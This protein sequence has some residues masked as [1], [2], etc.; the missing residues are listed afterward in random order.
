MCAR[1]RDGTREVAKQAFVQLADG[2]D[3]GQLSLAELQAKALFDLEFDGF[4]LI[5]VADEGKAVCVSGL[6]HGLLRGCSFV[7]GRWC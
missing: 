2:V 6:A 3:V 5:A 7:D 1:S 4:F